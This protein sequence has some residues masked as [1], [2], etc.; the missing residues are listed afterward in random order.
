MNTY[1]II[2]SL[3]I[4]DILSVSMFVLLDWKPMDVWERMEVLAKDIVKT[5]T[6]IVKFISVNNNHK[7]RDIEWISPAIIVIDHR[8]VFRQLTPKE[9]R[10]L[11]ASIK[12]SEE[13]NT[14]NNLYDAGDTGQ[15]YTSEELF[16][17]VSVVMGAEKRKEDRKKAGE[18]LSHFDGAEMFD[19]M[20]REHDEFSKS[21]TT[22]PLL[23]MSMACPVWH[24]GYA[25][26]QRPYH[27][28]YCQHGR[29]LPPAADEK[30]G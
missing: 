5:I 21:G 1:N 18:V 15:G 26:L 28:D 24:H 2:V 10:E 17:A 27:L 7:E 16:D 12:Y 14:D 6:P 13:E 4:A 29:R 23:Y 20:C 30:R 8:G 9:V 3:L 19:L 22:V 11:Y 25:R